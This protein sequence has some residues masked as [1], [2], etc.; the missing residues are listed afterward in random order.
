MLVLSRCPDEEIVI[1]TDIVIRVLSIRGGKVRIGIDAPKGV[2]IF[3]KEIQ[4]CT[5]T[6]AEATRDISVT[7]ST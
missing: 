4:P 7:E 2:P 3:R 6:A 5:S 1:G